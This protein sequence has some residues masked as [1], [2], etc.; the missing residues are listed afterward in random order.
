MT[1]VCAESDL[2]IIVNQFSLHL[3]VFNIP[4]CVCILLRRLKFFSFM[5]LKCWLDKISSKSLNRFKKHIENKFELNI[6][7]SDT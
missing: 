7:F 5:F 6:M 1:D 3:E 4:E 2:L